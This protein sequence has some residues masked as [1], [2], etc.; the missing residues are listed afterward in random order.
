MKPHYL[1]ALVLLLPTVLA[2]EAMHG[3]T[4][5]LTLLGGAANVCTGGTN[6][7]CNEAY[8]DASLTSYSALQPS[9]PADGAG[10]CSGNPTTTNTFVTM[11]FMSGGTRVNY[12][13]GGATVRTYVQTGGSGSSVTCAYLYGIGPDNSTLTFIGY[14]DRAGGADSIGSATFYDTKLRLDAMYRFSG[15]K[16]F[17]AARVSTTRTM[18]IADINAYGA[19]GSP[20][21]AF[22]AAYDGFATNMTW[23]VLEGAT[24]WDVKRDGSTI[25]TQSNQTWTDVITADNSVHEYGVVAHGDALVEGLTSNTFN[26][27]LA[28]NAHVPNILSNI[29]VNNGVITWS[30]PFPNTYD[31][32]GTV[33]LYNISMM[34]VLE[35]SSA[36]TYTD[37]TDGC[38]GICSQWHKAGA[39]NQ[40]GE[41]SDRALPRERLTAQW[42]P[43]FDHSASR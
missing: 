16:L 21:P 22:H 17:R 33:N 26:I 20:R 24:S 40:Y 8:H 36:G 32:T 42:R 41:T 9:N 23:D 28:A 30:G 29:Q 12:T 37:R 10:A 11:L 39:V 15:L 35:R 1:A 19:F 4:S 31:W 3:G 43:H 27:T 14:V 38:T 5:V 6:F 7:T 34:Q 18:N 13:I 2:D 25:A